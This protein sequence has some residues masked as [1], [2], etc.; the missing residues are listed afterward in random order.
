MSMIW[1]N[2]LRGS[3]YPVGSA[4]QY[5]EQVGESDATCYPAGSALA[6]QAGKPDASCYN[7]GNLNGQFAQVGKAAHATVL[8]N[9]LALQRGGSPT[10]CLVP[11]RFKIHNP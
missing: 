10:H 6:V 2:D 3:C 4:L 7:G 5:G 9:A 1:D 8:R 11:L